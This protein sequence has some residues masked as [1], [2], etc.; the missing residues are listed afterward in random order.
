MNNTILEILINSMKEKMRNGT[1]FTFLIIVLI[2]YF[3]ISQSLFLPLLQKTWCGWLVLIIIATSIHLLQKKS[4][5]K[6]KEEAMERVNDYRYIISDRYIT[7]NIN[8]YDNL[9]ME[10]SDEIILVNTSRSQFAQISGH[11]DFYRHNTRI[12]TVPFE[13]NDLPSQKGHLIVELIGSRRISFW[14]YAIV[15][16]TALNAQARIICRD[17]VRGS[18]IAHIPPNIDEL[19]NKERDQRWLKETLHTCIDAIRFF[20]KTHSLYAAPPKSEG[21]KK[22]LWI[23]LQRARSMISTMFRRFLVIL[24][25]IIILV[26]L[27][28]FLSIVIYT[29]IEFIHIHI[30]WLQQHSGLE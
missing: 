5:N 16:Y 24:G 8:S 28:L 26:I 12:G 20:W 7:V 21:W 27:L 30:G 4:R 18:L 19:S 17:T 1:F 3:D 22:C 23:T 15:S 2:I 25:G 11:I 9:Y 29:I 14:N 13:I 10:P 6:A